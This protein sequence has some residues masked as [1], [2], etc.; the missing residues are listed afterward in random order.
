ME[1]LKEL[2]T[3]SYTDIESVVQTSNSRLS[4][5]R[6]GGRISAANLTPL[7]HAEEKIIL[8]PSTFKEA[9]YA[10]GHYMMACAS[11]LGYAVKLIDYTSKD[12]VRE[13]DKREEAI[14]LGIFMSLDDGGSNFRFTK[15]QDPYEYGRT[16]VRAQQIVSFCSY[17]GLGLEMLKPNQEY[18]GNGTPSQDKKTKNAYV[19]HWLP[20]LF[21]ETLWADKLAKILIKLM[22]ESVVFVE[23]ST[24]EENIVPYI[25][26][27]GEYVRKTCAKEVV[28][29]PARGKTPPKTKT[30]VP[31]KPRSNNMFLKTE[32]NLLLKV[33]APLWEPLGWETLTQTEWF[34]Y[35]LSQG[36][37]DIRKALNETYNARATFL[38]RMAALTTRRLRRLREV[39]P[40]AKS[41]R[42]S[43]VQVTDLEVM[44]LATEDPVQ[45][46]AKEILSVDPSGDL[47]LKE[48]FTGKKYK[49]LQGDKTQVTLENLNKLLQAE[50]ATSQIYDNIKTA[51]EERRKTLTAQAAKILEERQ[52]TQKWLDDLESRM[53]TD[54]LKKWQANIFSFEP[55]DYAEKRG[56]KVTKPIQSSKKKV[57]FSVVPHG[58]KPTRKD[59]SAELLI[60][61]KRKDAGEAFSRLVITHTTAGLDHTKAVREALK[62]VY[63]QYGIIPSAYSQSKAA[64]SRYNETDD[65]EALN[66][67]LDTLLGSTGGGPSH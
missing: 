32:L 58:K 29:E 23:W 26:T 36:L 34:H 9:D 3:L 16:I 53:G 42:K 19:I 61:A 60:E 22:R 45:S 65:E 20:S 11:R 5:R 7:L 10:L 28:V 12:K 51:N 48:F 49:D 57:E 46:Y 55:K 2:P 59:R 31:S 27:Y 41:R 14:S 37:S 39:N 8:L 15:K 62:E 44:L 40:T 13:L 56:Y 17:E 24:L 30:V 64:F 43:D 63:D 33:S 66:T 67:E 1:L 21:K 47:F 52:A 35:I 18:F 38:S 54:L 6:L 25:L 4:E 50:I